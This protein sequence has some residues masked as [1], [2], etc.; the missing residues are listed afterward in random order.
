MREVYRSLKTKLS[1]D[2][3]Y[4]VRVA[5]PCGSV[6]VFSTITN[7]RL[8]SFKVDGFRAYAFT[9]DS[10]EVIVYDNKHV[11]TYSHATGRCK[12]LGL[13]KQMSATRDIVSCLAS[14]PGSRLIAFSNR[15][16]CIWRP[17]RDECFMISDECR[18]S[19]LYAALEFS[20]DSALLAALVSHHP[21]RGK[22]TWPAKPDTICVF[23]TTT[24]ELVTK[25]EVHNSFELGV[26]SFPDTAE[27]MNLQFHRAYEL[28]HKGNTTDRTFDIGLHSFRFTADLKLVF[29]FGAF[30]LIYDHST[31]G[32]QA[33][34]V[35]RPEITIEDIA[36]TWACWEGRRLLSLPSPY[37]RYRVDTLGQGLTVA[38]ENNGALTIVRF[39]PGKIPSAPARPSFGEGSQGKGHIDGRV[40]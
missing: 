10:S 37:L 22:G 27:L 31:F 36:R 28:A 3:R 25:I 15:G 38:I 30:Q 9:E 18:E 14:S 24:W 20:S 32:I 23:S 33:V 40:R 1:P 19:H 7:E 39:S 29:P 4:I 2:A 8:Y 11:A 6:D 21:N 34:E 12:A 13:S 26:H 17:F 35:P 5:T 16:I